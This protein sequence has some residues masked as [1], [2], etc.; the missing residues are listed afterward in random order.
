MMFSTS[1]VTYIATALLVLPAIA[2]ADDDASEPPSD[3]P[4][5]P[6]YHYDMHRNSLPTCFD[7]RREFDILKGEC[8]WTTIFNNIR[9]EY[10]KQSKEDWALKWYCHGGLTRELMTLTG[11]DNHD[12]WLSAL[13]KMC[14]DSLESVATDEIEKDASWSLLEEAGVDMSEYFEGG[15]FLNDEVGNLQQ[16]TSEFERRGGYDR[17]FYIGEDPRLNDYLPTTEESYRG[18]I[19]IK[20]FYDEAESKFLEPPG[21]FNAGSCDKTHA[22]MCC[23]SGDR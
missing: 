19:R 7:Y 17:Y 16:K 2:L 20:E 11:V 3:A 9:D 22:A 4:V 12:E 14:M 5:T 1:T 23:W 15:T 21:Q 13:E 8:K 6:S 10:E 18:G